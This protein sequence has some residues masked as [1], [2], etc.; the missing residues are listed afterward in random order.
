MSLDNY[1]YFND[2]R[3]KARRDT[4]YESFNEESMTVDVRYEDDNDKEIV[5]VLPVLYEVCY[6]C[7][8]KGKHVDPSIDSGGICYDD[9]EPDFEEEYVTGRYDV[10]CYGCKGKRVLPVVIDRKLLN[11][12][13]RECMDYLDWKA[14][15][16]AD[17]DAIRASEI[18]YGC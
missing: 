11:D 12:T 10:T 8:G 16:D 9:M 3:V 2:H 15:D 1:N 18:K 7:D 17:Y 5:V 14:Q 4:W 6:T 13:Q